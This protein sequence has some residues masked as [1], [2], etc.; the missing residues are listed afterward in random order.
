MKVLVYGAG[1]IGCELAHV[2][3]VGGNN[4]T[5]LAR[6]DWKDTLEKRGLVIRHYLQRKT[7][8]DKMEVIDCL[9][10][11][12]K[13]DIIF[14]VM[15]ADQVPDVL[16]A[17]AANVSR[18]VVFIG[19]NP[20][21]EK[22]ESAVQTDSPVEKEAAFGF[23]TAGGRRENGQVVSIHVRTHLTVGSR[24]GELSD[25][26][27]ECITKTFA[28]SG[29][30]LTW[31][32][33]MDAWLKCH[34]AEILPL[35]YVSYATSCS[36]PK[37]TKSQRRAMVDATAEGFSLLR[38]LGYPIRPTEDE[39]FF[40]GGGM[41]MLWQTV[42][43]VM[44][45][46][47]LGRLAVTDHCAHALSEMSFL[48]RA[49]DKLRAEA[50][51]ASMNIPMPVWDSLQ[52]H[53]PSEGKWG[54]HEKIRNAYK[55][56]GGEATFYDGMITC[57]TLPGK[58]ICKLVWN[59]DKKKNDRYLHLALSGIPEGFSGRMLEVPVGT[60]VLTMPVYETFGNAD[61][62]CLDYSADMMER[63][64]RQAGKRGLKNVRFLQGDVGKL[65]FEDDSFDLVLS[66]NGFHAFPD[67]E[68]AYSEVFRVLKPG[69]IFCGCFYVKGGNRRTDWFI[70]KL[71]TPKGFFT[72]PYETEESLRV[73]LESMYRKAEVKSV[74]GMAAFRCRKGKGIHEK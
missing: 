11:D 17:L 1:V 39:A 19:N 25:G 38:S 45:K 72:P 52:K 18:Y 23:M 29:C 60:G 69:G 62:T 40:T 36:L 66:L 41:R 49:W 63:A 33:Q 6:G 4:V 8:R 56:L 21:A 28:D 5:L 14:V 74:E 3:K 9:N 51:E 2:L 37:A 30:S 71:Y 46:T 64:K 58:A 10:P 73:R 55:S 20:W 50:A 22:T 12:D 31:E 15:Q 48:D 13:Y 61:I 16:P 42:M 26:F 43:F 57:S 70:E 54:R 53:M 34:M 59:M 24:D 47:P 44:C 67:K 65:P 68:A 27:R 35:G 32:N 7:T